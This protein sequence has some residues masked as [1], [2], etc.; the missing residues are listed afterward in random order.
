MHCLLTGRQ[1]CKHIL[2]MKYTVQFLILMDHAII[3][4]IIILPVLGSFAWATFKM[5][6]KLCY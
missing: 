3:T 2:I 6:C 5:A 4:N 1:F